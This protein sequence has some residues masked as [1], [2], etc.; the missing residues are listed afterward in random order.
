MSNKKYEEIEVKINKFKKEK[1]KIKMLNGSSTAFNIAVELVAGVVVGVIIGLLF[2][3]L[4]ASKPVFLIISLILAI[5][6]AFRS[7]WSKYIKDNG[8]S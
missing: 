5:I 6:A 3:N 4:F 7:I 8:T 2:D 1:T